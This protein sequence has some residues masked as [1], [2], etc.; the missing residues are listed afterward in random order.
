MKDDDNSRQQR[1]EWIPV[2]AFAL[3]IVAGMVLLM[4][5]FSSRTGRWTDPL[6]ALFTAT[7][8][9]CVTGLI[10]V[11]T[12]SY[13]SEFGQVVILCMMQLGGIGIMTMGTLLLILVGRRLSQRDEFVLMD[14]LHTRRVKGVKSLLGHALFFALVCEAAGTA[15]L[16]RRLVAVHGYAFNRALYYALFHAISAFCN[17]GFS[18]YPDSLTGLRT[19]Q[20]S[21]LTV[22]A[23]IVIGGLGFLVLHN[24][25]HLRWW[26]RNRVQR[27]KLTLHSRIV[28]NTTLFLIVTGWIFFLVLEWNHTLRALHWSDRIGAALF[29]SVTPRTAG[30]NVVDMGAVKSSTLFLTMVLMFVGGSPGS[31][32]GGIKTVTVVVMLATVGAMIRGREDTC[33]Y[34]RSISMRVVREAV[35]IS[36]LAVCFLLLFFGLLLVTEQFTLLADGQG[37]TPDQ[38]LFE[39]ISAIATVGLST[40]ITA[41]L[42]VLG[43]LCIIACMFIGRLGPMTIALIIGKKA[44]SQVIRFPEEEVVVG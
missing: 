15:I 14:S 30:F 36:I 13:F 5:P 40:G 19:D 17:A 38:I 44:V 18:L 22:V 41:K 34:G 8:A 29:Q 9:T 2:K 32:A 23:L 39:T 26:R 10:V 1:P 11:D 24:L 25:S 21:M 27:G 7:S 28:L 20:T 33:L 31:T 37:G 6:T 12:G 42:S 35:S 3:T 16:T 4:L 43:K